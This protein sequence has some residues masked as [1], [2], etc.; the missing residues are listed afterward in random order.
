M[1]RIQK[2]F[3]SRQ[4]DIDAN[5][6]VGQPG[7]LWFDEDTKTIHYSDG[8][9]VGGIPLSGINS[10]AGAANVS[11]KD[12]GT[13]ITSS[14]TS[15]NFV[16]AGVV[17][18]ANGSNVTITMSNNTGLQTY[19]QDTQPVDSNKYQWIQT[20]YNGNPNDFTIWFNNGV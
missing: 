16:G 2:F 1:S 12:E 5:T 6:Y 3:T 7:R 20:N 11:I 8:S 14:V 19:I 9:A 10:G 18:E 17:A 4:H 13:L 15:I